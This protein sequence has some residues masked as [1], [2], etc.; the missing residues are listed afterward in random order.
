M[1]VFRLLGSDDVRS[2]VR[3]HPA[4]HQKAALE[5]WLRVTLESVGDGIRQYATRV[6]SG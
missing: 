3:S 6:R 1:A 5:N 2:Y 4:K